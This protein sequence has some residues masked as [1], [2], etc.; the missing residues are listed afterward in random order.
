MSC[1][2]TAR[3]AGLA[4]VLGLALLAAGT[5]PAAE[6]K[7][8]QPTDKRRVALPGGWLLGPYD[9]TRAGAHRL[10]D[11]RGRALSTASSHCFLA[12]V[13]SRGGRWN[14][15]TATGRLTWEEPGFELSAKGGQWEFRVSGDRTNGAR[16]FCVTSS[17]YPAGKT[18]EHAPSEAPLLVTSGRGGAVLVGRHAGDLAGGG[19]AVVP[20]SSRSL[21]FAALVAGGVSWTCTASV[22]R[23]DWTGGA[24]ASGGTAARDAA[25]P[26]ARPDVTVR[27]KSL[28]HAE[29]GLPVRGELTV[30]AAGNAGH[31]VRGVGF[32]CAFSPRR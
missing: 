12:A 9:I 25:E 31:I 6:P 10:V 32:T 21:D 29:G 8:L 16:A 15:D 23:V 18:G 5:A 20:F 30:R 22:A 3:F 19:E 7:P 24:A 13:M 14:H 27:L 28:A 2:V 4:G 26:A 17:G 1:K 11:D